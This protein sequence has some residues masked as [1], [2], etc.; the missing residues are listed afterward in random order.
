MFSFVRNSFFYSRLPFSSAA[1]INSL[2][3][4]IAGNVSCTPEVVALGKRQVEACG[5]ERTGGMDFLAPAVNA[6][7]ETSIWGCMCRL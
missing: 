5:H 1:T 7:D 6:P 4:F 3:M 2:F